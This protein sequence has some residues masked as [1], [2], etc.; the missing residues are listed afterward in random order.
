MIA[1]GDGPDRRG[2]VR[3]V[4]RALDILSAFSSAHPRLTLSEL[5]EAV[6][7]PRPSVRRLAVTLIERG[8]LRQDPD[9]AYLLGVRLLELGSQVSE[10]SAITHRAGA[11]ADELSRVTGETV[12]IAEVDWDS[13]SLLI[14]GKRRP[15]QPPPAETSPVGRRYPLTSGCIGKAVLS[16]L[17]P[18]GAATV[19]PKLRLTPRTAATIVDPARLAADVAASRDRGYAIQSGEFLVGMA[20]AAVPVHVSGRVV[21]ALAVLGTAQRYPSPALHRTGRLVRSVLAQH[22]LA[23]HQLAQHRPV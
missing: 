6:G 16:G 8:F 11:A 14:I 17:T 10:S 18:E 1:S 7:L 5:A 23:Q 9:G 21:G 4:A 20:G 2:E 13:L 19:V 15:V 3:S 12:L 22:R